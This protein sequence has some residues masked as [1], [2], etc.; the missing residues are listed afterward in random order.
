[1]S[2]LERDRLERYLRTLAELVGQMLP[3]EDAAALIGAVPRIAGRMLDRAG[4]DEEY[5]RVLLAMMT[6]L[7]QPAPFPRIKP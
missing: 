1:M 2:R 4:T 5:R 3:P 6:R 7:E